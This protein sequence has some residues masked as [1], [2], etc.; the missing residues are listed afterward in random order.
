MPSLLYFDLGN[1]L[2][3]FDHEIACRQM[4][5]TAG[6]PAELVREVVFNSDLQTSYETGL[7]ST[8][9]YYA[10]FCRETTS[11]PGL[12]AL[13]QAASDIFTPNQPVIDLLQQIQAQGHPMGILSNTCAAHWEFI[14]D[15]RFPF[16]ETCFTVYALSFELRCMKPRPEI[17]AAAAQLAEVAPSDIFFIDDREENVTG[18]QTAGFEAVRFTSVE[19]L[20]ID[21]RDRGLLAEDT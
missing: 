5:V 18:A 4:A 6:V 1:V 15:G 19:Q 20:T 21:L 13:C 2:L 3:N 14:S 16:I 12:D 7:I 9:E 11:Q 10:D 17:Y 8:A